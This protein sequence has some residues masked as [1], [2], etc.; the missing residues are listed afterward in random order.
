MKKLIYG[1]LV[2]SALAACGKKGGGSNGAAAPGPGAAGVCQLNAQGQ[3]VGGVGAYGY[4]GRNT[5]DGNVIV[6]NQA[7]YLEFLAQNGLCYGPQCSRASGFFNVKVQTVS[8]TLP[9][10]ANFSITPRFGGY[11]GRRLETQ[12]DAYINAANNGFQLVYSRFN[13]GYGNGYQYGRPVLPYGTPVQP[14][15]NP[16]IAAQN[17]SLQIVLTYADATQTMANVSIVYMGVQIANGQMRALYFNNGMGMQRTGLPPG[18]QQQ[19]APEVAPYLG[20]Q[21]Y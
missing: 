12:A 20:N 18:V 10:A 5:W 11:G 4:V 3:C 21:G 16:Q 9:N 13:Y 8:D 15:V 1:L 14:G 7:K 19:H 6:T 2:V 17:Q